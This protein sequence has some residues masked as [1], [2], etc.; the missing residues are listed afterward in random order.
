MGDKSSVKSSALDRRNAPREWCE[1]VVLLRTM[2]P[3]TTSHVLSRVLGLSK[4]YAKQLLCGS[5]PI[6]RER[7]L[8]LAEVLERHALFCRQAAELARRRASHIRDANP[9]RR[10]GFFEIDSDGRYRDMRRSSARARLSEKR[11]SVGRHTEK[12]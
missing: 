1:I 5:K 9:M 12:A 3:W 10:R 2:W 11:F 8:A 7:L 6:G 4:S